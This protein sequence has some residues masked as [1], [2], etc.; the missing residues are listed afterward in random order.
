MKHTLV[1][2]EPDT[3]EV[4]FAYRPVNLRTLTD[5]VESIPPQKRVY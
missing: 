5:E 2:L 1:W 3:A 4:C